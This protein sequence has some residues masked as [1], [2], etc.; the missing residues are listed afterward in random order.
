MKL[1]NHKDGKYMKDYYKIIV[2]GTELVP[3]KL[4]GKVPVITTVPIRGYEPEVSVLVK[5]SDECWCHPRFKQNDT[6]YRSIEEAVDNVINQWN[7]Y[8]S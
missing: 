5:C 4:C 7:D 6:V 2:R 1:S 8:M 3:C